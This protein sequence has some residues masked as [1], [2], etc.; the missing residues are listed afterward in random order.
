M[1]G[2]EIIRRVVDR[3]NRDDVSM[4]AASVAYYGAISLFPAL[5]LL[6]SGLGLFLKWTHAGH[7]AHDYVLSA[8][9]HQLSP[10]LRD[11][12]EMVLSQ[13]KDNAG[14]GGPVGAAMLLL[15]AL[16]IFTQFER[17]FD[18]IWATGPRHIE[19]FWQTGFTIVTSRLRAFAMITG[20][21]VAIIGVFLAEIA[22]DTLRVLFPQRI[23][24][25]TWLWWT[26]QTVLG[27][28]LNAVVFAHIYRFLPKVRVA[29]TFAFRG[30]LVAAATWELG[31]QLLATFVIGQRY[32]SAYGVVGS[33]MAILLWGYYAIAVIFLGAEYT[34]VL[35]ESQ[36]LGAENHKDPLRWGPT[37]RRAVDLTFALCL[38]YVG[39]FVLL[40]ISR[41]YAIDAAGGVDG[42]PADGAPVV[43]FS[44][45]PDTHQV[46]RD[47]YAPLIEIM[48]LGRRFP[49]GEEVSRLLA[50]RAAT[51]TL[52][53]PWQQ[54]ARNDGQQLR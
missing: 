27:I 3:W 9:G 44:I 6:I 30:G 38:A 39:S 29:W 10:A 36:A 52:R 2:W 5:L 13:V 31:R 19:S 53:R 16:A 8:I 37:V 40:T 25:L 41:S 50:E 23:E 11:Q 24:D 7:D 47:F 48:P 33:L 26:A 49:N 1:S 35:R 15:A 4:L 51:E 42:A 28:C 12:I 32:T 43:V 22:L 34:Q 45:Q 20:L 54:A 17:A 21:A 46:T 18:R 14:F